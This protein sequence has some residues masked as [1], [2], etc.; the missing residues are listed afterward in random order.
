LPASDDAILTL[1]ATGAEA[2]SLGP[3]GR[4]RFGARGGTIGRTGDNDWVLPHALVSAHHALVDCVNGVFHI[5]DTST[6]GVFINAMTNRLAKGQPAVISSGDLI[7][8]QPYRIQATVV[9]PAVAA[10]AVVP[11]PFGGPP[12]APPVVR[13]PVAFGGDPAGPRRASGVPA[14]QLPSDDPFAWPASAPKPVAA[15][16]EVDPLK[17]LGV[18]D[19]PSPLRRVPRAEDLDRGSAVEDHFRPPAPVIPAPIAPEPPRFGA[20]IPDDYD[21][22]MASQV[23]GASMADDPF[24]PEPANAGARPGQA[25]VRPSGPQAAEPRPG[26]ELA[27]VLAGAGL[28]AAAVSPTLGRELGQIL[29]T[30]VAGVMDLLRARQ[31]IKD[32]FRMQATRFRAEDNNS[33]KFSANVGD[34]LHNLLVKQND[35]F[36]GPVDSFE[37]AFNDLRNHQFAMLFAMRAAFESMLASFAPERLQ[38][39]FDRRVKKKSLLGGGPEAEYWEL[40]RERAEEMARDVEATYR[41]LFGD[42]FVDAYEEQLEHLNTRSPRGKP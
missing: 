28:P 37:D 14:G 7:I 2:E 22:A 11:P 33:L 15:S 34:A 21:P 24:A 38:S 27:D 1:E 23:G 35:A 10:P 30:V 4:M 17:L 40:Y 5:T 9:R 16:D 12:P 8:I 41:Q 39:Q 13:P 20:L 6:N 26:S 31:Q 42:R 36:L 18:A 32:E 3:A 25:P 29:Q 19:S